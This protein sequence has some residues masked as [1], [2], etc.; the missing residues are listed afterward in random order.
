MGSHNSKADS[1][2]YEAKDWQEADKSVLYEVMRNTRGEEANLY[3]FNIKS[4]R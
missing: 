1:L 4:D 3:H 2:H